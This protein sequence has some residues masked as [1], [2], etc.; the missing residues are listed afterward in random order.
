MIVE[1]D[2]LNLFHSLSTVLSTEFLELNFFSFFSLH[3]NVVEKKGIFHGSLSLWI[4]LTFLMVLLSQCMVKHAERRS[5]SV[6]KQKLPLLF[7]LSKL[8]TANRLRQSR[9]VCL[10]FILDFLPFCF[11]LLNRKKSIAYT[12]EYITVYSFYSHFWHYIP[13]WKKKVEKSDVGTKR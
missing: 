7:V 8:Y 13:L 10:S 12:C 3:F 2:G 4:Y 9:K 6:A 1:V 11:F 5:R